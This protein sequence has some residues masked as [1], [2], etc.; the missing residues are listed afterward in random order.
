[1]FHFEGNRRS[2]RDIAAVPRGVPAALKVSF[3]IVCHKKVHS[4]LFIRMDYNEVQ[5]VEV[6]G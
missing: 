4:C 6:E 3:W 1:M 2:F 5:E